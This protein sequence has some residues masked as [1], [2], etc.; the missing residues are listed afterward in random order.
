MIKHAL[1]KIADYS[2][3][4]GLSI[5]ALYCV[6]VCCVLHAVKSPNVFPSSPAN[7]HLPWSAL[8]FWGD[9]RVPLI[10]IF[11]ASTTETPAGLYPNQKLFLSYFIKFSDF[12]DICIFLT[13]QA[14]WSIRSHSPPFSVVNRSST[15]PPSSAQYKDSKLS[16]HLFWSLLEIVLSCNFTLS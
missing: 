13:I 3:H 2:K 1:Q 14:K 7:C 12:Y 11:S 15:Q 4:T 9:L 8:T 10:L 5:G 16:S 6:H